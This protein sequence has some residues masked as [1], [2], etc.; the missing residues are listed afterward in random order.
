MGEP[1]ASQTAINSSFCSRVQCNLCPHAFVFYVHGTPQRL[2]VA[3]SLPS[4]WLAS[5]MMLLAIV[6]ATW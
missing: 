1:L 3:S 6:F 2:L 4:C 5:Q